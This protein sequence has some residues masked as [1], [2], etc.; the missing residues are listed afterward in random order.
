MKKENWMKEM[1]RCKAPLLSEPQQEYL[2]GDFVIMW[3]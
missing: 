3:L 2:T 1:M